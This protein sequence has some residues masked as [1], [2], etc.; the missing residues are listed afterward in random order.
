M[1]NDIEAIT[2]FACKAAGWRVE[3]AEGTTHFYV[4][5][6]DHDVWAMDFAEDDGDSRMLQVACR[7]DVYFCENDAGY[8]RVVACDT[9]G[10]NPAIEP[11]GTNA[12]RSARMAVLRCAAMIGEAMP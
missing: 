6:N 9:F 10:N 8:W 12:N 4:H 3:K 5:V 7:I 11:L 1:K 2:L